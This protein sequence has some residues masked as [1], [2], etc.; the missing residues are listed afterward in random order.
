MARYQEGPKKALQAEG[1]RGLR[2]SGCGREHLRSAG[3]EGSLEDP[4]KML[5]WA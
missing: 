3:K 2:L 5:N 4:Q 1:L